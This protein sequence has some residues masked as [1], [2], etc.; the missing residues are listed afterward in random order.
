MMKNK[1]SKEELIY[2]YEESLFYKLKRTMSEE[3]DNFVKSILTTPLV[4]SNSKAG[5]G[6]TLMAYA[7]LFYLKEKG[8]IDKIY[9]VFSPVEE[10]KMGFRPGT[11][12]EKSLDYGAPVYKAITSIGENPYQETD[13][14][15]GA[16]VISSHTFLRGDT[17]ENCGVIIDESQ[18][19][20]THELK[21]TLTRLS[22]SCHAVVIGH[23]GQID[24]H[25]KRSSGFSR[26]INHFANLP[27]E[28]VKFVNLTKNYRGWLASHADDLPDEPGYNSLTILTGG[29]LHE[30]GDNQA[31]PQPQP[32][33]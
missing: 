30:K 3:Q 9:Y 23:D 26:Y 6:K 19:F 25:N 10:G 27:E 7:S 1:M 31:Q 4:F 24:L 15:T 5:T 16:T 20:T 22:D 28:K 11:Q 21:K 2:Q 18:N 32:I 12:Q 8:I 13:E 33:R 17:F 29:D 14:Q